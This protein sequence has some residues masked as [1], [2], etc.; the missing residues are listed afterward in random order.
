M[1][2]LFACIG[3][4]LAGSLYLY[5]R[6]RIIPGVRTLGVRLGGQRVEEATA[7]LERHWAQREIRLEAQ[8]DQ[9]FT[10]PPAALGIVLDARETALAAYKLGRNIPDIEVA[11]AHAFGGRELQPTWYFDPAAARQGLQTIAEQVNV[12]PQDAT[13]EFSDGQARA[14]AGTP[15]RELDVEAT[16]AW[17]Q[18][19]AAT[20]VLEGEL[21]LVIREV[22][23][24]ITVSDVEGIAQ[25]INQR[26]NQ[27]ITIRAYDPIRDET[28]SG[29]IAPELWAQWLSV[30]AVPTDPDAI[31]WQ[32]DGEQ[33]A[34]YLESQAAE[35]GA[36]R[37][38][39]L[40]EATAALTG[41]IENEQYQ[42]NLRIY[43]HE[44]QHTVQPGE[45]LSSIAY[46]YGIPYPWIQQIN[47]DTADGIFPGDVLVIPSPDVLL[48]LPVVENKRIIVSISEQRMWAYENGTLKWDWP[49]STGIDSSPTAPG[50]FQVQSHESNAYAS[51]WDLWMPNFIGIYRPVPTSDFMNGFHGFPTRNG[52]NLLWTNSLGRKVTYGCI[53][54][55]ND[56]INLLYEWAEKGV[57]VEVTP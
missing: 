33:A 21:P 20:A 14:I 24:A 11:I 28:V 6:N 43:H 44:R 54:V 10:M 35:L 41:A 50:V 26:L 34:A 40:E 53:L 9:S 17:L 42:V 46:D 55:S 38:L 32:I 1:L 8:G 3:S 49:V 18:Q 56:N 12:A 57:V 2:V 48:P 15:G 39:N 52:V 22:E 47:P 25:Q 30:E 23:P 27:P 13:V 36:D 19:H 45:T 51:I 4:V 7:E 37:Y 29:N 16:A 5:Q 31:T